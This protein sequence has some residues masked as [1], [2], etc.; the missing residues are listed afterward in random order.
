MISSRKLELEVYVIDVPEFYLQMAITV[1]DV[2]VSIN[3][4]GTI[5]VNSF[6]GSHKLCF[7]GATVVQLEY[8][9]HAW[10]HK[11]VSLSNIYY[12][13]NLQL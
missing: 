11:C 13:Y 12:I 4:S 1:V 7:M 10:D 6:D 2:V 9:L 3:N 5:M 8:V